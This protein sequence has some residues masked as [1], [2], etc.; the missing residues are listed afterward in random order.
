MLVFNEGVP[1]SGKSYDAIKEHVLPALKRGRKVFARINGLDDADRRAKIAEYVGISTERLDELLIFVPTARVKRLFIATKDHNVEDGEW[2]IDDE[3]KDALFVID[4]VHEFY[5]ASREPI[6]PAIEQFFALCGQNGMDGVLMSQWY[7][8]LHSAVRARLER[9]NVFQKLTAVGLQSRYQV[10]RYHAIAPD[11]YEKVG[12]ETHA[13][14]SAIFPLYKGYADGAQNTA[15][16]SGGGKTVWRKIGMLAVFVVPAA[17]VAAWVFLGFFGDHSKMTKPVPTTT[18]VGVAPTVV[19]TQPGAPAPLPASDHAAPVKGAAS[20]N[21]LH[22]SFDTKG[23]PPEVSYLF[24]MSSQARPRLA[25]MAHVEGGKDWAV[26]EWREDQGHVLERLS[27]DQVRELGMVVEVHGYGLKLRYGKEA[28]VVTAWP[29][30]MPGTSATSNQA[31]ASP[32][33]RQGSYTT[34]ATPGPRVSNGGGPAAWKDNALSW[35]YT[36]PEQMKG[37][38]ASDWKPGR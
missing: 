16:Y 10:T 12:G 7:R 8:R 20:P 17:L 37:P 15:V 27:L 5:V 26:I 31:D 14:D 6:H 21:S 22:P 2:K 24:D 36:P 3:L 1:R 23:M 25:A 32:E 35:T 4:E 13:Y 9:K 29:V 33:G 28:I 18:R 11:R 34:V 19:G 38:G 30:D